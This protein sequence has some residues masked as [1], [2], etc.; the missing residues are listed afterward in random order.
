MRETSGVLNETDMRQERASPPGRGHVAAC[1]REQRVAA[2]QF[3]QT[4]SAG[5]LA[6]SSMTR[7]AGP[8]IAPPAQD[9]LRTSR[10]MLDRRPSS[11]AQIPNL[12]GT[13]EHALASREG[14]EQ[15]L[16]GPNWTVRL[17]RSVKLVGGPVS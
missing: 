16:R 7:E 8:A 14:T 13:D 3:L 9:A 11:A 5:T 17:S 1:V 2:A 10:E 4:C 12:H 6:C 15:R